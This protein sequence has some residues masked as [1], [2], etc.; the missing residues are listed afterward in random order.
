M[1]IKP[2]SKVAQILY[3]DDQ[4]DLL[5]LGKMLIEDGGGE[6]EVTIVT[7]V[8][9]AI[10]L[11]IH[12]RFDLII[13][14]YE[15]PI[16]NGLMFLSQIKAVGDTTPFI[17]FTGRGREEVV[18]QAI[19]GGAD[20]YVQKNGDPD[21]TFAE[22]IHH[23]RQSIANRATEDD[24]AFKNSILTA[25]LETTPDAIL[26]IDDMG[27]VV[28]YNH[29]FIEMWGISKAIIATGSDQLLIRSILSK[30]NDPDK[31]VARVE[32]LY[33][34]KSAQCQD[35]ISFKDGRTC[36]RYSSPMKGGHGEH[37][38]RVWYFRDITA[39]KKYETNINREQV[40]TRSVV[41][42][43]PGLFCLFDFPDGKLIWWNNQLETVLGYTK[44]E[45]S[46]RTVY[47]W[48]A[49]EVRTVA[50]TALNTIINKGKGDVYLDL[51]TKDG[52]SIP[53]HLYGSKFESDGK[54]FII[55]FGVDMTDHKQ[56]EDELLLMREK[57]I[58]TEQ[59]FHALVLAMKQEWKD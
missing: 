17:L 53:H 2:V 20:F 56:K 16:V 11:L 44:E 6:F 46:Q 26:I 38:G 5:E 57:L 12:K 3:V 30:I 9:E 8:P 45:L 18:M 13:S 55:G 42:S 21:V 36:Y 37:L 48:V 22:L 33:E 39:Q 51:S 32:E 31:F 15:M 58:A 14:D 24:R 54:T 19:N 41:D 52:R 25:Q 27:K 29:R 43:L 47:D 1:I 59:E 49:P 4:Q 7:N 40:F 34:N 23:I 50:F 35:E 10:K 28:S